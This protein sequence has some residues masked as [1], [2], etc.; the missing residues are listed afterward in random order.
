MRKNTSFHTIF[1]RPALDLSKFFDSS[2]YS[3][4]THRFWQHFFQ[5]YAELVKIAHCVRFHKSVETIWCPFVMTH[6][7]AAMT[8]A[9][10]T[11]RE[12]Q[13]QCQHAHA[14]TLSLHIPV[15]RPMIHITLYGWNM[16][17]GKTGKLPPVFSTQPEFT[18]S[19]G[20]KIYIFI[21][22]IFSSIW[23]CLFIPEQ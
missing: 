13:T 4:F 7:Q 10:W 1:L 14:H 8:A 21:P 17:A 15:Y 9:Q 18:V 5:F 16:L 3:S 6:K 2:V 12:A 22:S 19:T 23:K 20:F 11:V